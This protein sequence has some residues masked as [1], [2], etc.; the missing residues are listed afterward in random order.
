VSHKYLEAV[1]QYL[2]EHSLKEHIYS[3][4]GRAPKN[5]NHIEVNYNI[6]CKVFNYAF[7]YRD[8]VKAYKDKYREDVR[9]I[10]ESTFTNIWKA[11]IPSF[12]FMSPK[13]DLY[14]T[15]KLMK[16]DIQYAVQHKKN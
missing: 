1:E 2:R 6:A 12:Q 5:M 7:I 11:L 13:S 8:Y 10:A 4:T 14:K 9:V 16:M 15:C 3:N